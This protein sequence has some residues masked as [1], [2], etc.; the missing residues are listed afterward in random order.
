MAD[1]PNAPGVPPLSSYSAG[2]PDELMIA[3]TITG[4]GSGLVPQWGLYKD[5]EPAIVWESV[6]A[7]G[8]RAS[9]AIS[10]YPIERG[11]F[12]TYDR[13]TQP[14]EPRLQFASGTNSAAR[15]A[16]LASLDAASADANMTK[17][18]V[19]TPDVVYSSVS[20]EHVDY[21]RKAASGANLLMIDVWL[22]EVR[23]Q[24]TNSGADVKSP[25]AATS[26][27]GG[28]VQPSDVPLPTPNP[29]RSQPDMT[30]T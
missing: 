25:S 19:V 15:Q 17:Y 8:F 23:E 11:G 24:N 26:Q 13:V 2:A 30:V 7:F 27:D 18:D 14:F 9:W 5:G 21:D 12:E 4:Y 10:K 22:Q 28:T 29:L 1:V 20:I 16:L 3:D 6:L